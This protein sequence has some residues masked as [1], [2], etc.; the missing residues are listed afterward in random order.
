MYRICF[1]FV[2]LNCKIYFIALKSTSQ[3]RYQTREGNH[4]S[5]NPEHHIGCK[6]KHNYKIVEIYYRSH[7]SKDKSIIIILFESIFL[8]SAVYFCELNFFVLRDIF[9]NNT[10]LH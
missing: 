8:S 9:N 4:P 7:F 10:F 1:S 6:Y 3:L 5:W 2:Y